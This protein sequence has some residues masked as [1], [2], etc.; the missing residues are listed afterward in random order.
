M[1]AVL[2]TAAVQAQYNPSNP[3]E[4]NTPVTKYR[5]TASVVPS[6]GGSVSG[7]GNY[8]AGTTVTL[9]AS[10]YSSYSFKGWTD[11]EGKT[12]STS[13]RFSFVMGEADTHYTANFRY[14]PGNPAEPVTPDK[15]AYV[16]ASA[17]PSGGGSVSGGGRYAVGATV[18][19]NASTSS[20]YTFVSWTK[21]G[22]TLGTSTRLSYKVAEEGNN[23]VANFRYTPGNP[24]E[25][26][27][28]ATTYR[29]SLSCAPSA[30]GSVSIWS[31][32]PTFPAGASVSLRANNNSN[33]EFV[34]W[35]AEDGSVVSSYKSFNY[36]MP[37]ADT[38]LTANFVYS[39][40]N[41]AEPSAPN[42]SRNVLFGGRELAMP[43]TDFLYNISL[44][45]A[46]AITGVN[47]DVTVPVGVTFDMDMASLTVRAPEHVL[48]V[49]SV[50]DATYRLTVRG[51]EAISGANG[52]IIR[53]PAHLGADATVDTSIAV[54]LSHG[55]VYKADGSQTPVDAI[56][57]S[58]KVIA[59]PETLPDSPD[60]VVTDISTPAVSVM[61]GDNISV[62]WAVE[63]RGNI[64]ST[65]GW[66]ESVYLIGED[67]R[68][69]TLGTL[70]YDGAALA[71]GEKVARSA[72]FAVNALPG[73]SGALNVGVSV[74]PYATSGEIEQWQVNNTTVS[75]GSPV[76]LGKRL[77]LEIPATLTE[78]TDRTVRCRLARS[79]SWS[80][81]EVFTITADPADPRLKVP[82]DV[83]IYRDQSA[84]YFQLT[85]DDN[86]TADGDGQ[87][88]L[89]ISGS[90]YWPVTADVAIVDDEYPEIELDATP[91]EVREGSSFTLTVTLPKAASEDVTVTLACDAAAR[92]DLPGTITVKAGATSATLTVT[93]VENS[94]VEGDAHLTIRAT[95]PKYMDGDVPV[96]V[97]DNDIPAL[98]LELTPVEV[99]ENAGASAVQGIV[100]RTDNF[101]KRVTILLSDDSDGRLFYPADRIVLEAGVKAAEFA[102]GVYDNNTVDGDLD[103]ALTA[104]VYISSCSCTA[105]GAS[106]GTVTRTLR[107][108]D[109]DGPSIGLES[110]SSVL[111]EGDSNG[112]V[113][114]VSRNTATDGPLPVRVTSDADDVLEYSHDVTIPAGARSAT[115]RVTAP[116]NTTGGDSRAITFSAE[117]EGFAKGTF[118]A[119]LTDRSLP[120]ARIE[121]LVLTPAEGTPGSTVTAT[122]TLANA[123]VTEL[124]AIVRTNVYLANSQVAAA[125]NQQPVPA[126]GR[127]ELTATFTLPANPGTF[128]VQARVNESKSVAELIYTNNSSPRA[129]LSVVSPYKAALSTDKAVYAQGEP[130]RIT[131]RLAGEAIAGAEVE[132]YIINGG[133]RQTV[134]A[135]TG[136]DGSFEAVFTPYESQAGHF[137][138]GACYPGEG[139][140]DEQ[141][142]FDIYRLRWNT[143]SAQTCQLTTGEPYSGSIA[144]SNPGTLPV[145]GISV[146]VE[147][148]PADISA[149]ATCAADAAG[150]A[151]VKVNYTVTASQATAGSDWK[152]FTLR[153]R[154]A[155]AP[156]LVIPV[157]YF[158]S[159]PR[160]VLEASVQAINTTVCKEAPSEYPFT[161]MNNGRG[162]TGKITLALPGWMTAV[163]PAEMPSLAPGESATVILGLKV[164]DK[165]NL[166]MAVTGQIGINCSNG[167]GL[168]VPYSV[169][170]VSEA[171][172][173]LRVAVCDEYTY[174]TQEAP[175]VAGA[176]VTVTN[177]STGATVFETVTDETG[178]CTTELPAGYYRLD[179]TA[180]KHDQY[181]DFVYVSAE[182]TETV[183]V[184]ISYN[185]VTVKWEV[186]E[187]TVEDEYQ[188]DLVVKY[189][190]NVPRPVVKVT[191]PES[192]DGDHMAVGDAVVINMNLTNVGLITATNVRSVIPTDLTEW[193]FELLAYQDLFELAPQQSV[194][195]PI[196]ITRIADESR[197]APRRRTVADDMVQTYGNCMAAA[198]ASYEVICGKKINT[199]EAADN[200][201]M[202]MCAAAATA[203][204]MG[205]VLGHIFRNGWI[206][207]TVP[208]R[209]PPGPPTSRP[210]GGRGPIEDYG[211]PES[212][213]TICDPCDAKMASELI[214][215]LLGQTWL[216]G[217]NDAVNDAIEAYREGHGGNYRFIVRKTGEDIT[218]QLRDHTLEEIFGEGADL[219]SFAIDVYELTETCDEDD[220][221][222]GGG[223]SSWVKPRAPEADAG[224][225]WNELFKKVGRNFAEQLQTMHDIMLMAYGDEVW[226][227]DIDSEKT[228]FLEY[229]FSQ[230]EG[231]VMTDEE[232]ESMRPQS[233]TFAQARALVEYVG[234]TTEN[235]PAEET[236]AAQFDKFEAAN[237]TAAEAGYASLTEQFYATYDG[238]R[239]YLKDL[240]NNSVCAS[241]SLRISQTMTMTRQAFRGTL[242]VYN[243]HDSNPMTDV[244]LN[245]LVRDSHGK[246]AGSHEFQ[247]NAESL[248]GFKGA[249]DLTSGWELAADATGKAT[250]LFIPTRY[251]APQEPEV[252]SFGGSLTYTDPYTGLEI[253]RKLYPV[254]LT[255]KPSP[256]LDLDYFMQRDVMADDPLTPDVIEPKEAA[257]F[258]LVINNKGYGDATDVRLVTGQPEIIENEKGLLIDFSLVS[259]QLNGADKVLSL[260]SS[261]ATDFGDIPAQSTAYAQWWLEASLL[262]HFL[263]YDVEATHVT[264]YG[265]PDLSLLS[266]VAV[267]ELIHGFTADAGATPATRA[268]LVNDILDEADMPDMVYFSDGSEAAAVAPASAVSAV[269]TSETTAEL[270]VA[271]GAGESWYY[272]SAS[273]PTGGRRRLVAVSRKSDGAALP[274]DNAWQTW[275]TLID[276]KDPVHE[277]RIH[278]A[279][280][281]AS[282][283]TYVLTF[284]DRP[285]VE[286]EVEGFSGVETD[287]MLSAALRE[288]GVTFNKAVDPATFTAEDITLTCGGQH[289]DVAGVTVTP[290]DATSFTLGLGN[291]TLADGYY[292]LT[293]NTEGITDAE[294]FNGRNGSRT[295][296]IQYIDGKV[297]LT[298]SVSPEGAGTVSPESQQ[299]GHGSTVSFS[300]TPAEGYDFTGWMHNGS[301]YTTEPEFD[302]EMTADE[303]FTATFAI[304]HY[305]V[306]IVANPEHGYVENASSGIYP[307]GTVLELRAR[308]N[309][310][311]R[312]GSWIVDG[313]PVSELDTHSVTVDRHMTIL[314]NFATSTGVGAVTAGRGDFAVSP[315]PLHDVMTVT[316]SYRTARVLAVYDIGGGECLRWTDVPEGASLS[317]G[318]LAPGFYIIRAETDGGTFT[319]KVLKK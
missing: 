70:Y 217:F 201:R 251:A 30:G 250:V 181:R 9:S 63:N 134:A 262:G 209:T 121:S 192:I 170:P 22:E 193:R 131:G 182:R 29:L 72:T 36:T 223:G 189:E 292:V 138:V 119:M 130:V 226:C 54:D 152:Q 309:D 257:E 16:Y 206:M 145:S 24:A 207:P 295:S 256:E 92:L 185:P 55:V 133:A 229:V 310:G 35:T 50:G 211:T 203:G 269:M 2:L 157:Y 137:S 186:E 307:H 160:G 183:S 252:Y 129:A 108:I 51:T 6:N 293:V 79:G 139:L 243:G 261:I 74:I 196:R 286:L 5:V 169:V 219:V 81:T 148:A 28:P 109:N 48:N 42:P 284:E 120:D 12:V 77:V 117:A 78:G 255:V 164:N 58:V 260:G 213:F 26:S 25:P 67:G 222:G 73:I 98:E 266:E 270:T 34:N 173:T 15:Y 218:E 52:A 135:T 237:A 56:D 27:A 104:S 167:R 198:G 49:E 150:G 299:V 240:Q 75:T 308:P 271:A 33:Y 254:E 264:S 151:S 311:F 221:D 21:D 37:A 45:N 302:Y 116:S 317:V 180:E 4:P 319:C 107:I 177:P 241:I 20:N 233:V 112:L 19:L 174:Y 125:Y 179:V 190:T 279:A 224:H 199:N 276:G 85:L 62:D 8:A 99:V 158:A 172:G 38:R 267:H 166:N 127:T 3:P 184:D 283:E 289:V 313:E 32:G 285:E 236:V 31:S 95:A 146:E 10:T 96:T 259:S 11:S 290:L 118:W 277:A 314:A 253:T 149:T 1:A 234:G 123:G 191:L 176:K 65:G 230:P 90:D 141:A 228:G 214:D 80:E 124:P 7:T 143:S 281:Q 17:L 132:V 105:T 23:V 59:I 102:I 298:V 197:Q 69:S 100:R 71:P 94:R 153:V 14:T 235:Y 225:V 43:G 220:A 41:P 318:R 114:T 82:A 154:S 53:I 210:D 144:F 103:V 155:E 115:V 86:D 84:A 83:T 208:P 194:N 272:G 304:R 165:M 40:G 244:R 291:T 122:M 89:S 47:I 247:I 113:L 238:Y 246:V 13:T 278:I 263:D 212:S 294:G 268:F 245:L 88:T 110:S 296:W 156:D 216:G 66:S 60:F 312:F 316:G 136:A 161:I 227:T 248:D 274:L 301:V 140:R 93:A 97:I 57:G 68:R 178:I 202:K 195:V 306:D 249:L 168:T 147:N 142:A 159:D 39:P 18:T 64:A 305:N 282:D 315:A 265:N 171:N 303:E 91:M 273:D 215:V 175:N 205:D 242:T 204:V 61:P 46:D 128:D 101:D 275:C 297:S 162:E 232:I 44:E 280:R 288:V 76:T 287:Q 188:I 231:T 300:A 163:T 258:A 111:L 87:A 106:G 200:M 187:T 126:G 239:E